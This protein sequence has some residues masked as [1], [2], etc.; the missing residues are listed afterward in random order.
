MAEQAK[1]RRR[2]T[3]LTQ[4]INTPES[5]IVTEILAIFVIH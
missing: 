3:S 2:A 1:K 4:L 5:E